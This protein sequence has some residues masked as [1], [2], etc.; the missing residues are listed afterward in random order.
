MPYKNLT[1]HISVTNAGGNLQLDMTYPIKAYTMT[2][3]A[4]M[5]GN[6]QI[7]PNTT[8]EEDTR[9]L[10]NYYCTLDITTNGTS[11]SI[12]GVTLTS[13]Q[14]LNDQLIVCDYVSGSW[15]VVIL[16]NFYNSNIVGTNQLQPLSVTT[17][18]LTADAVTTSKILD[19]NVTTNKI[20]DLAVTEN[21]IADNAVTTVKILDEAVTND[22]LVK[23]ASSS[24]KY[25]D[26]TGVPGDLALAA[27][28]I[29]V[30]DGTTVTVV[31]QDELSRGKDSYTSI[32][33]EVSFES[34]SISAEKIIYLPYAC[35][36]EKITTSVVSN[37]ENTNNASITITDV[38]TAA[39][40][41]TIVI[42]AGATAPSN[43]TQTPSYTYLAGS[44]ELSTIKI[45]TS[46]TT[47]GGSAFV[48]MLIKKS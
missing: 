8:P 26:G 45:A 17:P 46:K 3:N 35:T 21:K 16:S 6:L 23:M 11:V 43:Q 34:G 41:A 36:I 25:G 4:V 19:L 14:A 39:T 28:E 44:A 1:Q 12:F 40:I 29:P 32:E 31:N 2:G 9:V 20:N 37:I 13:D 47:P 7:T 15:K 24:V 18:K 5:I 30:G 38:S 27:G 33:F 10:I 22:K 42:I 48:S